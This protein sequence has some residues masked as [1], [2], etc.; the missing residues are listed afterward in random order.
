MYHGDSFCRRE[1]LAWVNSEPRGSE[2]VLLCTHA[3]LVRIRI[4]RYMVEH[5]IDL[6]VDQINRKQ[7]KIRL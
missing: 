1:F 4:I 6:H 2:L 7:L 3:S 5:N